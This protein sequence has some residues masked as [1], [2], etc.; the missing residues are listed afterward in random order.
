MDL[1]ELFVVFIRVILSANIIEALGY[2]W[3]VI[4]RD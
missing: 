2:V 4:G 3:V 1:A